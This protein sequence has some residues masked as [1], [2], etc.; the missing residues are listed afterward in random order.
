MTGWE[1][2]PPDEEKGDIGSLCGLRW[3]MTP[4]ISIE[5]EETPML[6]GE[7]GWGSEWVTPQ[8]SLKKIILALDVTKCF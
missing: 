1:K 5:E 6:R 2:T 7:L 4:P 8:L 3:G